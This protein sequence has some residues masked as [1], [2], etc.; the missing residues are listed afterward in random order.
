MKKQTRKAEPKP[1]KV[2]KKTEHK[3]AVKKKA[4]HKQKGNLDETQ[5]ETEQ[6]AFKEFKL[7]GGTHPTPENQ[8]N[9]LTEEEKNILRGRFFSIPDDILSLGRED[10][11]TAISRF[12]GKERGQI[13][14]ILL[15][16][17]L[18]H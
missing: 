2:E 16:D 11:I 3:K 14:T 8:P 15:E 4:T 10:A 7:E 9:I 17:N 18:T 1:K 12:T 13:S 6:E 5:P